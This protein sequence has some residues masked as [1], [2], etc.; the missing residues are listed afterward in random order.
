MRFVASGVIGGIFPSG[1]STTSQACAPLV[2]VKLGCH[3]VE[4]AARPPSKFW[5]VFFCASCLSFNSSSP[6]TSSRRRSSKLAGR[7]NGVPFSLRFWKEPCKSGSPHGVFGETYFFG[8]CAATVTATKRTTTHAT[9][10]RCFM[11][12]TP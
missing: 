1:G 7:S 11:L 5:T 12:K 10:D 3:H 8:A 4:G 6:L 9:E 2:I